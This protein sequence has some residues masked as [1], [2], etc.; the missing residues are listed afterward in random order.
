MNSDA[1]ASVQLR[2]KSSIEEHTREGKDS[3]ILRG[4]ALSR[5]SALHTVRFLLPIGCPGLLCARRSTRGKGHRVTTQKEQ[6]SNGGTPKTISRTIFT[7]LY[8]RGEPRQ[9]SESCVSPAKPTPGQVPQSGP[10]SSP[11]ATASGAGSSLPA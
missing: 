10:P 9:E 5:S 11:R 2:E 6:A 8:T 1:N 4:Q 3:R 7:D